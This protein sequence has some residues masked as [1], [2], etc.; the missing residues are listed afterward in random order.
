MK[1]PALSQPAS[2]HARPTAGGSG[3]S[4]S[5]RRSVNLEAIRTKEVGMRHAMVAIA[6]GLWA[7]QAARAAGPGEVAHARDLWKVGKDAESLEALEAVAKHA[8]NPPA[9]R[10]AIALGRADCLETTGEPDKAIA[11]LREAAE[12]PENK[13]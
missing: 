1:R 9:V 7:T 10:D 2:R 12:A 8:G 4:P 11:A 6:I 13:A 3:P 5:S